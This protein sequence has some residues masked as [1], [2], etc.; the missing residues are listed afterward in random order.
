[1]GSVLWVVIRGILLWVVLVLAV[2]SWLV[3]VFPFA[4]YRLLTWSKTPRLGL[5][6]WIQYGIQFLDAILYRVAFRD[7]VNPEPWPWVEV[8]GGKSLT[9]LFD[10]DF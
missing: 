3:C 7:R 5:T 9:D 2:G 4:V 6:Y 8:R 1:M 10:W